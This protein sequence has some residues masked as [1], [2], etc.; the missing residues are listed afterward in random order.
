MQMIMFTMLLSNGSVKNRSNHLRLQSLLW[1]SLGFLHMSN[2]AVQ[3]FGLNVPG[4]NAL[5]HPT[6][7]SLGMS[8][9]DVTNTD[10]LKP[11]IAAI[12]M[13]NPEFQKTLEELR[14]FPYFRLYSC[15]MLGSCEYMPQELF[16]CYS[17]SCEIYPVD[18][19][20]VPI[21]IMTVDSEEHDF[22]LDGWARW[23]MPTEDYYDTDQFPEEYTAYD[24]SM[25][26]RFIHEK[27]CFEDGS[28][29]LEEWKADF[30]KAVSGLHSMISAQV[31]K[32]METKIAEGDEEAAE[33]DVNAEFSRR[34]SINGETPKA[35]EN[36]YFGYMLMLTAVSK[37]RERILSD[38]EL[39]KIHS[40]EAALLQ[41]IVSSKLLDDASVSVASAK[42]HD[43]AVKDECSVTAL[44]EARMRTRELM[45]IMNCVQCNKCRLHGKISVL[46]LST[47][48]QVLLGRTGEGGDPNRIHRVELA[49]MLTTLSKFSNAVSYCTNFRS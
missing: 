24:G 13:M 4:Y 45:R 14:H 18:E 29:D 44:W 17:Q 2:H 6:V 8:A 15:D 19:D 11:G 16:E 43:H 26:W 9:V 32:G 38:I 35:L 48:L 28:N 25:V 3:A 46:G 31:V 27:I 1:Y 36:L 41:K 42:L 40:E 22:E 23:D 5:K 12:D 34:L 30:N 10:D 7:S 49:A 39:D 21:D 37:A 47:A 33:L 20:E